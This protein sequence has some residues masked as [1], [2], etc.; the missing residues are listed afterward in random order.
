VNTVPASK[1]QSSS[2]VVFSADPAEINAAFAQLVKRVATM[3]EQ[4]RILTT[5][6]ERRTSDFR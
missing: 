2:P 4:L 6:M 5:E 3:E 1:R